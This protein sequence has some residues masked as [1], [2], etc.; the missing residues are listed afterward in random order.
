MV[1]SVMYVGATA[2]FVDTTYS[3]VE[4]NE[5]FTVFIEKIGSTAQPITLS[6]QFM[7]GTATGKQ[8]L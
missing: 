8:L 4:G 3:V 2:R 6:V 5:T 1:K 7:P